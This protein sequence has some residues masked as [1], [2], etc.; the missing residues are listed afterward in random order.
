MQEERYYSLK[1]ILWI[2]SPRTRADLSCRKGYILTYYN[3]T[4]KEDKYRG[5]V[6][7]DFEDMIRVS[8]QICRERD[9]R[10][11]EVGDYNASTSFAKCLYLRRP[12]HLRGN[13]SN[14]LLLLKLP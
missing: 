8:H 3:E 12:Q 13:R 2:I 14:T 10:A 6:P 11:W 4:N 1:K 9:D 7:E 5:R